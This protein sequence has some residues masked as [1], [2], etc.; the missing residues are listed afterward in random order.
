MG[1]AA[2]HLANLRVR[3]VSFTGAPSGASSWGTTMM[4][5]RTELRSNFTMPSS[6]AKM[7]WSLPI[8]V[9]GPGVHC[10]ARGV[11]VPLAGF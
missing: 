3:A 10:A 4:R 2:T 7:V 8:I 9:P 6:T 5:A 1:R 11:S